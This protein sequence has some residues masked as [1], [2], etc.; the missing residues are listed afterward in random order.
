VYAE[1]FAGTGL[2]VDLGRLDFEDER[3]W[4]WDD[5]LEAARVAFEHDELELSIAVARRLL[6]ERSDQSFIDPEEDRVLRWIGQATWDFRPNHGIE[7]FA[8]HHDDRSSTERVGETVKS[9]RE[10]ESD[11]RLRWLGA[12]A[13]GVFD[14]RPRATLGYWL[15]LAWLRGRERRIEYDDEATG[16]PRRSL[17]ASERHREVDG[18]GYDAGASVS[19][20][21][22]RGE[23]RL[24]VGYARASRDFRQTGIESDEAGFGGVERFRHYG[25]LLDPDFTNLGVE[26]TGAGVSLLRSSSLDLVYHRYRLRN[27]RDAFLP[28][29]A[30]EAELEPTHRDLG[31]EIDLVLAIEEWERLELA[32]GLAAFRTGR[33]FDRTTRGETSW[34]AFG[35]IRVAF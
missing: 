27:V 15:D 32:F 1:D 23:P 18:F 17:V 20:A 22:I 31:Q 21:S 7:L 25:L 35:A 8:V 9:E 6:P 26:T 29:I 10:D 2:D 33:A 24:F 30:L 4:W 3:R 11:A 12:R 13:M 5:E 34:G 14:L 19:L 28:D 16:L